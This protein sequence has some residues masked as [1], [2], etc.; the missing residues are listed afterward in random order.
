MDCKNC[1]SNLRDKD[2]F[3]SNCGA[4]VIEERITLKFIFKE[5]LD[6]VLSV[7]NKLLKT[8]WHLFSK[9]EKVIDGYINGVRK[10]YF[11]PF[12]YLLISITLAGISYYFLKDFAM[13]SL[14]ATPT[15]N[16]NTNNPFENKAFAESL[17]NFIFDYQSLLT[18]ITI[19]FYGIISWVVFLNKKKYNY[20]EHLIIYIYATAQISLFVFLISTPLFFINQEAGNIVSLT[21]SGLSIMYNTYVLIRLFKLTFIQT[22]IKLLYF[23]FIGSVLYIVLSIL[24]TIMMLVFLGTDYFKQFAP[25]KKKDSI[26]NV[27]P[28]DSTKAIQKN[29]SILK[30]KKTISYYEATSKLNCLSYKFL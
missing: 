29:D 3:C 9:P 23:I 12:S 5:I 22:I 6:K 8:F 28:I 14:E 16:P 13:Q 24:T 2:G 11:N 17:I 18:A 15:V 1:G 25:V 19:P 10:K 26:Q 7:D 20:F 4:R 21:A 27:Q 30:D